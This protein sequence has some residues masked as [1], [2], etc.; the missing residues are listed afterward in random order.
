M[1]FTAGC[2]SQRSL[3]LQ[4][5]FSLI[6]IIGSPFE[7]HVSET[8]PMWCP[9]EQKIFQGK[10]SVTSYCWASENSDQIIAR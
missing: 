8:P 1:S 3:H 4:S 10:F 5:P 7:S 2:V 6:I 9:K